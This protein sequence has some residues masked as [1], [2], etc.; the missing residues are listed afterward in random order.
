LGRKGGGFFWPIVANDGS[1]RCMMAAIA[2]HARTTN[3]GWRTMILPSQEKPPPAKRAEGDAA[4]LNIRVTL[5]GK[6]LVGPRVVRSESGNFAYFPGQTGVA[7]TPW[8][9]GLSICRGTPVWA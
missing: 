4:R 1:E 5:P 9:I 6:L 8:N 2:N 3:I 7:D